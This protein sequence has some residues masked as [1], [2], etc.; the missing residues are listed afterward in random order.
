VRA[1]LTRYCRP[2]LTL[3]ELVGRLEAITPEWE[4]RG[5]KHPK[6]VYFDFAETAVGRP[7]SWRGSYAELALTF[8]ELERGAYYGYK[9]SHLADVLQDLKALLRPGNTLQG[10]KGGEYQMTVDTPV[11]VAPWGQSSR[12]AVVGTRDLGVEVVIDTDWCEF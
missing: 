5:E 7:T 12:T 11:W 1:R 3:S 2:Q 8:N 4:F 6:L 10:W 9:V